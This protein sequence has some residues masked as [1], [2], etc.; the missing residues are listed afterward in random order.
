MQELQFRLQI[1]V[2]VVDQLEEGFC[3]VVAHASVVRTVFVGMA[4]AASLL[5][6]AFTSGHVAAYPRLNIASES[7]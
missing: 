3:L 2:R 4:N 6:S 1:S 7:K 5:Y